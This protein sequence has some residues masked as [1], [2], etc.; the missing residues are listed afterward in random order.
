MKTPY[1]LPGG[2]NYQEYLRYY[3]AGLAMQGLCTSQQTSTKENIERVASI[4]V[5]LAD[6]LIKELAK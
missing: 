4:S 3:Y 5:Q 1:D 6:I 2:A